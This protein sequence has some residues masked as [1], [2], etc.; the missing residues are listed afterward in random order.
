MTNKSGIRTSTESSI[1]RENEDIV[2]RTKN[3]D[4][5]VPQID[6]SKIRM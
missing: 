6:Y 5:E 2:N 4:S 1:N 3:I